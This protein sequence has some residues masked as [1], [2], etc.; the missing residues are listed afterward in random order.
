MTGNDNTLR[1][2]FAQENGAYCNG[3]CVPR[4]LLLRHDHCVRERQ[5]RPVQQIRRRAFL[6]EF[7]GQPLQTTVV[8][9]AVVL[10]LDPV[11]QNIK[12]FYNLV[13]INTSD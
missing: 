10:I 4:S 11:L 5:T 2:S 8:P 7:F 6:G 3:Y 1:P 12:I 9:L 13:N